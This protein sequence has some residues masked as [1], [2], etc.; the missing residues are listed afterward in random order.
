MAGIVTPAVLFALAV[1][2]LAVGLGANAARM[3]R[4]LEAGI[5]LGSVAV[6][7]LLAWAASEPAIPLWVVLLAVWVVVILVG[8]AG[9][10]LIRAL[11]KRRT[12]EETR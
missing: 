5:C 2:L 9:W 1:S 8:L 3:R 6:C 10:S 12:G 7:A 11:E 4:W